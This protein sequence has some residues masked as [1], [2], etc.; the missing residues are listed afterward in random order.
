M[1]LQLQ[2]LSLSLDSLLDYTDKDIDDS[3]FEVCIC[4]GL[5]F[6]HFYILSNFGAANECLSPYFIHNLCLFV[7]FV[8]CRNPL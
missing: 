7:A 5:L 8:I 6:Q 2:S 3:S 4:L 1:C